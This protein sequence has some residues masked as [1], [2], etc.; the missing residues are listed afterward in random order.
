MSSVRKFV[1]FTAGPVAVAG[2]LVSGSLVVPARAAIVGDVGFTRHVA[3]HVHWRGCVR[4]R[5]SWGRDWRCLPTGCGWAPGWGPA[6]GPDFRWR[7]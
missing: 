5:H 7:P 4:Y 1:L 3:R 2:L 6:W